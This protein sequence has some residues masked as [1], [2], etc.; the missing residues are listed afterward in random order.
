MIDHISQIFITI[1]SP[2]AWIENTSMHSA[3]MF[4]QYDEEYDKG[5]YESAR[6]VIVFQFNLFS[7]CFYFVYELFLSIRL[8]SLPY[9][10]FVVYITLLLP[11]MRYIVYIVVSLSCSLYILRFVAVFS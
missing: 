6:V 8:T 4:T 11:Y 3:V 5:Q 1:A 10:M 2:D 9:P 7:V